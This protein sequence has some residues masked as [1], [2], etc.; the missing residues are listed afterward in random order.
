[1]GS[2][3]PLLRAFATGLLAGFS[4]EFMTWAAAEGLEDQRLH[5]TYQLSSVIESAVP[6]ALLHLFLAFFVLQAF[7]RSS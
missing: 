4:E 6:F 3:V 1:M 2:A 7:L 5:G